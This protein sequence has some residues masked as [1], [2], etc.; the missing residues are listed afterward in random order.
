[1]GASKDGGYMQKETL[2]PEQMTL[3][4]S[5]LG[6]AG[7]MA[8]QAAQGY[9]QFLPGGGGGQA[10]INQANN[11]FQQQTLP[12]ILNAFGSNSKGGSGLNQALAAG[13]SNLN[14]DLGAILSKLQLDAAHGLGSLANGQSQIG[15]GTSPFAYLQR[16]RPFWEQAT[17]AGINSA[18]K[19]AGVA[20]GAG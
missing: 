19:A 14:T 1:M 18:G 9:Q 2:S 17:L 11:N 8:Q 16:D 10:I 3:L 12:Q 13:A 15:L 20:L 7:P 6:Q 4:Q 5:V